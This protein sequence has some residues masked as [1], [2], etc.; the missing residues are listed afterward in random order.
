[1]QEMGYVVQTTVDDE[2][3]AYE[4][5]EHLVANHL[6]ACAQVIPGITAFYRWDDN[7]ERSQEFLLLLKT[8]ASQISEL[9]QE[10]KSVHPYEVPE[11]IANP[12]THIDSDYL[13]WMAENEKK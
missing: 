13:E 8:T 2:S 9:M 4:L 5:A 6:C 12:I 11:I 1:M 3:K 10:I 7:L